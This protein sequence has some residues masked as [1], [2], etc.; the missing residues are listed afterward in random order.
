MRALSEPMV[1]RPVDDSLLFWFKG[2]GSRRDGE[3]D[4]KIVADL[5]GKGNTGIITFGDGGWKNSPTGHSVLEFDGTNTKINCGSNFIA[6]ISITICA[7]IFPVGFG[8]NNNGWIVSN[9]GGNNPTVLSI[10]NTNNKLFVNFG[11]STHSGTIN[12]ITLNKWQ[13]VT[14]TG[15]VAGVVNMYI[16]GALNGTA[17]RISAGVPGRGTANVFIGNINNAIRTFD[18]K[19]DDVRIFN[20]VIDI[21]EINKIFNQTKRFYGR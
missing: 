19:I 5:S 16:D 1:S 20:K 8:E 6:K 11:G 7:W 21:H 18:G 17:N 10:N 4:A 3:T 15:T 14:M 12:G 2:S 9:G 13:F